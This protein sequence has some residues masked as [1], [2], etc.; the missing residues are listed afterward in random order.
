MARNWIVGTALFWVA[1]SLPAGQ[2]AGASEQPASLGALL[3]GLRAIPGDEETAHGYIPEDGRRLLLELKKQ[4]GLTIVNTVTSLHSKRDPSEIRAMV[5]EGLRARDVSIGPHPDV[6]KRL[7]YGYIPELE[8]TAS[9][10]QASLFGVRV[11]FSLACGWQDADLY[12]FRFREGGWSKVLV[13]ASSEYGDIS[14]GQGGFEYRIT[15]SSEGGAILVMTLFVQPWCTSV[16][17]PLRYSIYRILPSLPSAV[18]LTSGTTDAVA[19]D[20]GYDIE[21]EESGFSVTYTVLNETDR[22]R[23]TLHL[24]VRGTEVSRSHSRPGG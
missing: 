10:G 24:R 15:D 14:A 23:E 1:T 7:G 11:T 16:W 8:V 19:I 6:L 2:L 5:T 4:V 20:E 3:Q 9:P 17:H 13:Q 12:L 18:R 22:A 21:A